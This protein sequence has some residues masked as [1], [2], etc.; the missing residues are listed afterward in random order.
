[1]VPMAILMLHTVGC[2][3]VLTQDMDMAAMGAVT[4]VVII[5]GLN[6]TAINTAKTLA[7][8]QINMAKFKLSLNKLIIAKI[9]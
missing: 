9:P 7:I 2:T 8:K 1:M 5:T 4:T 3:E 6:S